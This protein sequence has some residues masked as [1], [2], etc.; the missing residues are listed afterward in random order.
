MGSRSSLFL[1]HKENFKAR[2]LHNYCV[3]TLLC[4][5]TSCH[6]LDSHN[7]DEAECHQFGVSENVLD[8]S[9]ALHIGTV[10]EDEHT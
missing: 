3:F 4:D 9:P 8:Q 10:N 1:L 2:S 5:L 6:M 7:D